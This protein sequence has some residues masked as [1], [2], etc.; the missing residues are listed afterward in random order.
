MFIRAFTII[1]LLPQLYRSKIHSAAVM[2]AAIITITALAN[3][4]LAR[5]IRETII[6][7]QRIISTRE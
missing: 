7:E 4:G 2:F 3:V 1:H 5:Y 6:N